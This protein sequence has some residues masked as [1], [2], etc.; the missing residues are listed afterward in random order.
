MD[1]MEIKLGFI[2]CGN[3]ASAMIK[4]ILSSDLEGLERIIVSARTAATRER[5]EREFGVP[6]T[7]C[8]RE[9]VK[10]S[11]I[12][13]LAVKPNL[14]ERVLREVAADCNGKIIV[15]IAPGKDLVF[16]ENVLGEHAKI[17][18]T[19]PNTPA[20]TGE[21]M[22]A[23]C[24]NRN[25]H[26]EELALLE[27]ILS[28]FGKVERIEE[29]LFDTVVAVSGSSPAYVFLLIEAMADAA[30]Q[31]GM[32]RAQAYR[33]A[34]QAVLGS[35]KLALETGLHPAVLK[36]M[37]CSPGGTTIEGVAVLESKGLRAAV[38]EAMRH[39]REKSCRM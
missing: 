3:M 22:T 16:F 24:P 2:G 29:N 15:S 5:A 25:I 27:K 10:R 12:I 18:R 8:N 14:Y 34:A 39:V 13:F 36:D 4:G 38:I 6:A 35:A 9:V 17:L 7:E 31:G 33:F 19:M 30:V 21:G 32:P 23:I 20:M 26:A 1:I 28:T 11:D 37:V